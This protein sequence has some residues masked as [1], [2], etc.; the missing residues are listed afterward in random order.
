MSLLT[1]NL[2]G[3]DDRRLDERTEAACFEVLLRPEPVTVLVFQELVRRSWHAHWKHHLRHAG[4]AVFPEDPTATDS[5]Y[6]SAVAVLGDRNPG[7]GGVS[8]FPG[9]RMGRALAWA[10]V[11]GWLV[12]TGH[13]ESERA[14]SDERV[15]QLAA[16]VAR[17]EARDGPAVFAGDTNLRVTEEPA[18]DGLDRAIDV[19]TALGRPADGKSTWI[20]GRIGARFDRIYTNRAVQPVSLSTF[21]AATLPDLGVRVSD[22]LGLLATLARTA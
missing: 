6:F 4:Y 10:E 19:W 21:G 14:G 13:L 1:W 15:R 17:L 3:L 11:G 12:C 5:E 20:G 2:A 18:V 22:H 9:S 16:V 8:A 7:P